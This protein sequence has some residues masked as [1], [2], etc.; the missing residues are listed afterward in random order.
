MPRD[1]VLSFKLKIC[2]FGFRGNRGKRGMCSCEV[3]SF[4]LDDLE[5]TLKNNVT[6]ETRQ[7]IPVKKLRYSL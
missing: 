3:L 2:S 7:S 6:R 5:R 1:A 4:D